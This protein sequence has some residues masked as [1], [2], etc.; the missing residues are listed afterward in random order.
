MDSEEILI[1]FVGNGDRA[2]G[3]SIKSV[4]TTKIKDSIQKLASLVQQDR[5]S[6]V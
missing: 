1:E 3:E 2:N 4:N 6:V 5:K